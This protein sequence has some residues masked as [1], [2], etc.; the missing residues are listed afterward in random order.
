MKM[1]TPL[2]WWWHTPHD[3]IER[4]DPAFLVRDTCVV[5]LALERLL[6]A[7][8]LPLDYTVT[9]D[10]LAAELAALQ[11]HLAARLDIGG[12][13]AATATLRAHAQA[14]L[15]AGSTASPTEARVL[16]RALMRASR[17]LVPLDHTSG[18]RFH[19]D[20]ALPL[21][22][23]ASLDGLREIARLAADSPDLPFFVVHATQTRNRIAHALRTAIAALDCLS[24]P[25]KESQHG[26]CRQ[27]PKT[28][29]GQQ[30]SFFE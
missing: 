24:D 9:A 10:A 17:A 8:T 21:N 16:N 4:I 12:L 1:R 18:E 7:E 11:P 19:H 29:A 2:G 22:T 25:A 13:I 3:L 27:T 5:L 28:S 30:D 6:Q 26:L 15:D 14:V 23:W 20:P